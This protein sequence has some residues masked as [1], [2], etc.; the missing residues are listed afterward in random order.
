MQQLI[1]VKKYEYIFSLHEDIGRGERRLQNEALPQHK[2]PIS[3]VLVT[4]LGISDCGSSCLNE[5]GLCF[6][7]HR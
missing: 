7:E 3:S 6:C 4:H 1:Q 5:N 2:Q